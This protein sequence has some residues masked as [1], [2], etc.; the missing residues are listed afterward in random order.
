M[1]STFSANIILIKSLRGKNK[2]KSLNMLREIASEIDPICRARGWTVWTLREF[3]P[4]NESLLGM[5]VDC[6]EVKLRLRYGDEYL[7]YDE[8]LGTALHELAHM[9]IG[10]HNKKFHKLVEELETQ[11]AIQ[12]AKHAMQVSYM[13]SSQFYI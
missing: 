4:K 2:Q 6:S 8:I 12:Q 7:S 1:E 13:L 5:N 3:H 10:P 9:E 11:L